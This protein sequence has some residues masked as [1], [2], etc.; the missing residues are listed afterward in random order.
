MLFPFSFLFWWSHRTSMT[1]FQPIR[2]KNWWQ[3]IISWTAY[4]NRNKRI[5]LA[6]MVV[7]P[8]PF[9]PNAPFLYPLKTSGNPTVS[10]CFQR[11]EKECVGNKWLNVNLCN[12]S[13]CNAEVYSRPCQ[14]STM[15]AF[16]KNNLNIFGKK[17]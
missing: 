9:V 8:N 12:D 3:E 1:E 6:L 16:C 15:K 5:L 10:W 13:N 14:T 11:V 7:F 2:S 17:T 4:I